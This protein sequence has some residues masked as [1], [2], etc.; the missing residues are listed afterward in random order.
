MTDSFC[1][2]QFYERYVSI[3]QQS[4]TMLSDNRCCQILAIFY[5]YGCEEFVIDNRL[6]SDL[7]ESQNRLNLFGGEYP[8]AKFVFQ[9]NEYISQLIDCKEHPDWL[10][11]F[12]KL[13]G[14]KLHNQMNLLQRKS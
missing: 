2:K 3:L 8:N 6:R 9:M 4:G 14:I 12:E 11:E 13:Y 5:A 10:I 1:V 7:L